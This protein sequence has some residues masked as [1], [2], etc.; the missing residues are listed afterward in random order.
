MR[1]I[2]KLA[3]ALES[4]RDF[5]HSALAG[6]PHDENCMHYDAMATDALEAYREEQPT[7]LYTL[8][9]SGNTH[10]AAT[11]L[12]RLGLAPY[13][14]QMDEAGGYRIVVLRMTPDEAEPFIA[15]TI[16]REA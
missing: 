13:V 14:L 4:L 12:N 11:H 2:D 9:V 5:A 3:R 10:A 16:I 8:T 7:R 6:G 15:K 1:T